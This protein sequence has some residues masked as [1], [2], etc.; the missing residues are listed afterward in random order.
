[1][2][3]AEGQ[4]FSTRISYIFISD[5]FRDA[6]DLHALFTQSEGIDL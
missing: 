4:L 5:L 6:E 3:G 1:M 2:P